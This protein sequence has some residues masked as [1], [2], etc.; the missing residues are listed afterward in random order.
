MLKILL[1]TIPNPPTAL[2]IDTDLT[3]GT[4]ISFSWTA[5][6]SNGGSPVT[7][8]QISWD[9]GNGSWVVYDSKYTS[10]S[11][12]VLDLTEGSSYSF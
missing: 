8:Y 5:P 11:L 2:T 10:T 7:G 6:A 1:P 3:E 9:Q 12:T 4:Q